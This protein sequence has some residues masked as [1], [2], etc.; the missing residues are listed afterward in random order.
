MHMNGQGLQCLHSQAKVPG[1]ENKADQPS[2]HE[3]FTEIF[4][5]KISTKDSGLNNHA[6]FLK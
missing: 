4:I 2:V 1:S 5:K 6:G 3:S